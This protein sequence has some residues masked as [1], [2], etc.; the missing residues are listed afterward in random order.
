MNK[1]ECHQT[2][3]KISKN[4]KQ[5]IFSSGYLQ[6][7]EGGMKYTSFIFQYAILYSLD[8]ISVSIHSFSLKFKGYIIA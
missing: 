1:D 3:V 5:I 8:I 7:I 2:F 6:R 4:K